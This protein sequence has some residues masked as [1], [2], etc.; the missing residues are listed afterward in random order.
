MKIK[1][2][3]GGKTFYE[4]ID[5]IINQEIKCLI[6]HADNPLIRAADQQKLKK[7]LPMLE[8]LIVIDSV[9]SSLSEYA[10]YLIPDKPFYMKAGSTTNVSSYFFKHNFH[11]E[12]LFETKNTDKNLY[13]FIN[14]LSNKISDKD[15]K[16][17]LE[18]YIRS[19]NKNYA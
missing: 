1:P 18:E 10:T 2:K 7:A 5:A 8:N 14:S 3:K 19:L 12:D 16:I 13:D 17:N 9:Q 4:M 11:Q 6:I 15:K